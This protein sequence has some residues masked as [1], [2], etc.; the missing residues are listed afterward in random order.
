MTV[1][2]PCL[3]SFVS[4]SRPGTGKSY[5][6][7]VLVRALIII[8]RLWIRKSKT[9]GTP[10]I[11]VLSYKNLAIDN[12]L[13][14]LV[15]VEPLRNQLIRIGGSCKDQRLV[16]YSERS[17][18]Q[19]DFEVT[20]T[21]LTLENLNRL[22]DSIQAN[23][24][25]SM[26]SFLSYRNLMF[27]DGDEKT[28]RQAGNKATEFLME[29]I[30][31][32]KLFLDSGKDC[33]NENGCTPTSVISDL[34]FVEVD[35]DGQS[36]RQVKRLV[37]AAASG[38]LFVTALVDESLQYQN[39]H[40]GDLLLKWLYGKQP[41]PLCTHGQGTSDS[42]HALALSPDIPLCDEHRCAFE[43]GI[44]SRCAS[45]CSGHGCFCVE[46]CCTV[47]RC[48][49]PRLAVAEMYCKSHSCKKCVELGEPAR[50]AL[51]KPPRN[52]CELHPLCTYPSCMGFCIVEG[53]Y[54]DKHNTVRCIALTKRGKPCRGTPF[55]VYKPF[56]HDHLH[57]AP[58][59]ELD[60]AS[61]ENDDSDSSDIQPMISKPKRSKC[62]AHT[63]KGR[64]CQ[65]WALPGSTYCYDHG[66]PPAFEAPDVHSQDVRASVFHSAVRVQAAS[67]PQ[68]VPPK[69]RKTPLLCS[70]VKSSRD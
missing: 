23:L 30:I 49:A 44:S 47:T 20:A 55:S 14:D 35:Q 29:S 16:Q 37:G 54:C 62:S 41:L 50:C 8:R 17:T 7:V 1:F 12:F 39:E 67:S 58:T 43:N 69:G 33:E 66:P 27:L 57:L 42:C 13:V 56:C 48:L 60:A 65:G 52:V 11:L 36:C 25:G 22:R 28:R 15:K 64:S 5:L 10:P 31:R 53:I 61:M 34:S 63:K 2:L 46:H 3:L 21:R 6:G 26:A 51:D 9:S 45:S 24:S 32:R 70:R 40:W 19:S 4:Q 68:V 38:S 59:M 18:F